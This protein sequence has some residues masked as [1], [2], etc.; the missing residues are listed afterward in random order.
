M[1]EASTKQGDSNKDT[2]PADEDDDDDDS[3]WQPGDDENDEGSSAGP[4]SGDEDDDASS[5]HSDQQQ[6]ATNDVDDDDDDDILSSW[7]SRLALLGDS[8]LALV[9][10]ALLLLVS[11]ALSWYL[12]NEAALSPDERAYRQLG[13]PPQTIGPPHIYQLDTTI[14]AADQITHEIKVAYQHDGV[15]AI[16]GLVAPALLHDMQQAADQLVR[17]QHL[18]NAQKRFKVRGKQFFTVNHGVVFRTPET[19]GNQTTQAHENGETNNH[20]PMENP[21][22][23]LLIQS[24]LPQ[25]AAALLHPT[26][27]VT[28][29]DSSSSADDK[30]NLRLLRDIFLAKDDDPCT[31]VYFYCCSS[32]SMHACINSWL[33]LS[34]TKKL[35]RSLRLAFF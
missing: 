15:V 25:V 7:I 21:F 18:Q 6:D 26:I 10:S 35:C 9:A 30:N 8:P 11:M 32:S 22:L 33:A 12:A 16:R 14:A 13:P 19:L 2:R 3:S 28:A 1:G 29:K 23:R 4:S 34:L 24:S 20:D 17:E 5:I 27:T 31:C